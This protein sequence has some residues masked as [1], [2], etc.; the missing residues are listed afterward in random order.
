[1]ASYQACLT[2]SAEREAAEDDFKYGQLGVVGQ[3]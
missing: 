3:A 1:M 2:S